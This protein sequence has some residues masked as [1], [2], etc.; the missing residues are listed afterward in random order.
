MLNVSKTTGVITD[1]GRGKS[2]PSSL[3]ING[4]AVQ[5]TDSFKLLGFTITSDLSWANHTAPEL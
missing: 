2:V 1:F 4:V 5:S 3:L